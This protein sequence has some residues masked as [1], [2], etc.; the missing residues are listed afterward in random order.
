MT[1]AEHE[2]MPIVKT[3]VSLTV[4]ER[5]REL[6]IHQQYNA[7]QLEAQTE[8]L[9]QLVVE[10]ETRIA[11]RF[12]EVERKLEQIATQLSESGL[13]TAKRQGLETGVLNTVKVFWLVIGIFVSML[14]SSVYNRL[15]GT[16]PQ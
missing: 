12:T 16:P 2:P 11:S 7:K 6:E 15:M 1:S 10:H 8:T 5:L 4:A 14:V 13:A 9:R 3:P